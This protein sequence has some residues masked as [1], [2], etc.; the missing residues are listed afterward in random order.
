[1]FK[2]R[3]SNSQLFHLPYATH[4]YLIEPVSGMQH[5]SITLIRNF[6]NFTNKIKQSPKAV[7]R[8]LYSIA[9]ADVRTTT[10]SNLR[11]ILLQTSL[12]SVDDLHPGAVKQLKYMEMKDMDMWRI[13]IIKEALDIRFGNINPPDGWTMDEFDEILNFACTE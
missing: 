1:M 6:L 8:H 10:G 2:Y 7:L 4:W 13:P 11:N 12:T 5:M 3:Y 9:K